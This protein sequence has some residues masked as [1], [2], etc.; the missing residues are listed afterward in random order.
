MDMSPSNLQAVYGLVDSRGDHELFIN[1]TMSQATLLG[2]LKHLL[3]AQTESVLR[4]MK[5]ARQVAL[6]A[7]EIALGYDRVIETERLSGVPNRGG[8]C[9]CSIGPA[10]IFS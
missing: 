1:T 2:V 4:E 5:P 7:E 9:F 3:P 8:K 10:I 6:V